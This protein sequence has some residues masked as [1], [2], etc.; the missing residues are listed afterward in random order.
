MRNS[1]CLMMSSNQA[2][3]VFSS[4]VLLLLAVRILVGVKITLLYA[5]AMVHRF[6]FRQQMFQHVQIAYD[7]VLLLLR[8][9]EIILLLHAVWCLVRWLICVLPSDLS[10]WY[11]LTVVA[12]HQAAIRIVMSINDTINL[13]YVPVLVWLINCGIDSL[14]TLS[15]FDV[16]VSYFLLV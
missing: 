12:H 9:L 1:C 5:L 16:H 6:H 15:A 10:V 8:K 2:V 11:R 4:S 7:W 3:S 13:V 14:F